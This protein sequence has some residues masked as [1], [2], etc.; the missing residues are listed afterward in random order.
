[1]STEEQ[2]RRGHSLA[3]QIGFLKDYC[4]SHG[5]RYV[6]IYQENGVSGSTLDR[7]KFDL[8]L[9]HA[10]RR[11]FDAVIVY[12][13][14]RISCSNLDLQNLVAYLSTLGLELVSATEPFNSS[15]INGKLLF[16]LLAGIAEW[17]RGLIRER[18]KIGA[19]GRARRGLWHGGSPPFVYKYDPETGRL[20]VHGEEA[21]VVRTIFAKFL[22]LGGIQ[23][24]VRLLQ[25]EGVQ[26][27]KGNEWSKA[28]VS[29]MLSSPL[30]VGNLVVK[31]IETKQ[32]KLRTVT[33]ETFARVQALKEEVGRCHIAK[34]GRPRGVVQD[35]AEYCRRCG[36]ELAGAR[37]Y[38]ANCGT[39]Q[40]LPRPIFGA[41]GEESPAAFPLS[42]G[43]EV[44]DR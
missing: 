20:S 1:V 42:A 32:P 43:T 15:T 36:K 13:L 8:M 2:A 31:D 27:R 11:P 6:R 9:F 24:L 40:W 34:F 12:R 28:T 18:T 30:Y 29:R 41:E 19:R 39:P 33:D 10:E 4:R 35:I 44:A 7:P 38:C 14:D 21:E 25:R 22:E 37:A 3:H 16:D 17:E 26:T 23:P 5:W